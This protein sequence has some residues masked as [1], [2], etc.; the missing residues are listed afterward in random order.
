MLA[1]RLVHRAA[2]QNTITFYNKNHNHNN[3][4]PTFISSTAIQFR[5]RMKPFYKS[6]Y[7]A[8]NSR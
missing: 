2:K 8:K 3:S 1:V 7:K 6:N 4:Q 5:K